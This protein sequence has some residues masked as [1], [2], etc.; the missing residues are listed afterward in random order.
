MTDSDGSGYGYGDGYG[1]GYGYTSETSNGKRNDMDNDRQ[2]VV[3][4]RSR[5][6]GVF[7]GK[8]V[9]VEGTTA[10]LK[11]ARRVWYWAGAATLSELATKGPAKPDECKFPA[12]TKGKHAIFGVCEIISVTPE[13]LR[14][15]DSV[16][17]WTE[18]D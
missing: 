13:A 2:P 4:V 11:K 9:N 18:H 7:Y 10:V 8:L 5:D 1:S 6:A 12:P 3:M 16:P 14:T 15:L 17:I